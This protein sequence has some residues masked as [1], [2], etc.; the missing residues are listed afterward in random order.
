A[1]ARAACLKPYDKALG[2]H[3]CS[4]RRLSCRNRTAKLRQLMRRFA[5]L[6]RSVGRS[7]TCDRANMFGL[8]SFLA[9][10]SPAEA[11]KPSGRV[12]AIVLPLAGAL[13]CYSIS[14]RPTTNTKGALSLMFL[15]LAW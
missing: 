7:P 10:M 13:K 14:R 11:G 8:V 1:I 5:W 12:F 6:S 9:E 4:W 15:L 2:E 3:R